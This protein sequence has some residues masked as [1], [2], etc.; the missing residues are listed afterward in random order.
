MARPIIKNVRSEQWHMTRSLLVRTNVR[1]K[2][3]AIIYFDPWQTV[4]LSPAVSHFWGAI[5]PL[6]PFCRLTFF[7]GNCPLAPSCRLTLFEGQF[8]PLPLYAVSLFLTGNCPLTPFAYGPGNT[9]CSLMSLDNDWHSV[10]WVT[11][12]SRC[13]SYWV[14]RLRGC[15]P[16][17]SATVKLEPILTNLHRLNVLLWA[18]KVDISSHKLFSKSVFQYWA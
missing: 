7:E 14:T 13:H 15:M 6:D 8:P 18:C 9:C 11:R 1:S 17:C 16:L 12:L 10:Y 4:I 2:Y 5:A 3:V